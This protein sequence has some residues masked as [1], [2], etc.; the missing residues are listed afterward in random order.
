MANFED[1]TESIGDI[2]IESTV[3]MID[4]YRA[5]ANGEHDIHIF[6]INGEVQRAVTTAPGAAV[7][8]EEMAYSLVGFDMDG[9]QV[10]VTYEGVMSPAVCSEFADR[11]TDQLSGY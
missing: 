4:Y 3:Y 11:L 7:S 2:N 10:P 1:G 9:T 5:G 8:D 6:A